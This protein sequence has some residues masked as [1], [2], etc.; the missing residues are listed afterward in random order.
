MIRQVELCKVHLDK[1][2]Y[3]EVIF[4]NDAPDA[5]ILGT[6][7]SDLIHIKVINTDKNVGIHGARIKGLKNSNSEYLL[8]LDQDDLIKPEYFSSQLTV[9]GNNDASICKAIHAGRLWWTNNDEFEKAISKEFMLGMQSGRNP[10]ASPGQVLLRKEAIP[11]IW[12]EH[13][14]RYRGADDWF[15]WLCMI[16]QGATFALNNEVLYEHV[17]HENNFSSHVVELTESEQEVVRY[18]REK[19]IFKDDDLLLL[20]DGFF[21]RNVQL[22]YR[23]DSM[24][25][26]W[27][28]LE[29]IIYFREHHINP[30][31]HLI[32]M[33]WKNVAIYGCAILGKILYDE[34]KEDVNVKYFIDRNAERIS[35]EIP[36]YSLDDLLPEVDVIIIT[37]IDEA[38]NV[39]WEIEQKIVIKTILLKNWLEEIDIERNN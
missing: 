19:G 32:K 29:K 33:G 22:A 20:I 5:P 27:Y 13:M 6:Y 3:L 21:N 1:D 38:E 14:F 35:K 30:A 36:V 37:L 24:N 28:L 7:H 15:L 23:L 9:I 18:I 34:L 12:T 26:K 17:V 11:A 25:K 10:I 4:V 2:N 31:Q 16:A 39:A 8:F